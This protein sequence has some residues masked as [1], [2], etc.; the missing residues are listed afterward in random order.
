M[1]DS[2][3]YGDLKHRLELRL[4]GMPEAFNPR[5]E[6]FDMHVEYC[7]TQVHERDWSR[8]LCQG[9]DENQPRIAKPSRVSGVAKRACGE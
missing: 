5:G 2:F 9:T 6:Y 3:C 1:P 8:R 7:D 4:D